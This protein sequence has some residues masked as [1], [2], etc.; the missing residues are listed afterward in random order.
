MDVS[1]RYLH[2]DGSSDHVV[3][4]PVVKRIL[5]VQIKVLLVRADGT[6]Q[7]GDVVGVQRAGL[8]GQT[9]GQ[10]GVAN[11]SHA[12][13][14]KKQKFRDVALQWK[15]RPELLQDPQSHI[16]PIFRSLFFILHSSGTDPA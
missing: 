9:A 4:G 13:R 12:L 6:H 8:C 10:V 15:R 16:L 1:W 5:D 3:H 7:L 11:V 2:D 14:D